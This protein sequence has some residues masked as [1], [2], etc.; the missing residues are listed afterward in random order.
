MIE[1][2]QELKIKKIEANKLIFFLFLVAAIL[3]MLLFYQNKRIKSIKTEIINLKNDLSQDL[4]TVD[5]AKDFLVQK[6]L[7]LRQTKENE[8]VATELIDPKIDFVD[9]FDSAI[10]ITQQ[11]DLLNEEL[12]LFARGIDLIIPNLSFEKKIGAK[13]DHVLFV[14]GLDLARESIQRCLSSGVKEITLIKPISWENSKDDS[15]SIIRLHLE[16][17]ITVR[18]LYKLLQSFVEKYNSIII[19]N[20]QI[21]QTKDKGVKVGIDFVRIA[22]MKKGETLDIDSQIRTSIENNFVKNISK[23]VINSLTERNIFVK[24]E[25]VTTEDIDSQEKIK[26]KKELF[27][28][29]GV[30]IIGG[31][32]AAVI[33]VPDAK[34]E[35]FLLEGDKIGEF[36]VRKIS[37]EEVVLFNAQSSEEKK[38]KRKQNL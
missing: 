34:G 24:N 31:K 37:D 1:S 27:E 10:K 26:T 9:S 36:K 28:Y 33:K 16:M 32:T 11:L 19:E 25:L 35:Q 15:Y 5:S 2:N 4:S 23:E 30:I 21:T 12:A 13:K 22:F 17:Q 3:A 7:S 14:R 8:I 18:D 38:I 20:I 6:E 29:K